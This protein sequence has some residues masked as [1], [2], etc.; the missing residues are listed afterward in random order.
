LV[1]LFEIAASESERAVP[2]PITLIFY[3]VNWGAVRP[4]AERNLVDPAI[5]SSLLVTER[6]FLFR[7]D[8]HKS[9]DNYNKKDI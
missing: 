9:V 5:L 3:R 1:D 7:V 2:S 8:F 4:K 6:A